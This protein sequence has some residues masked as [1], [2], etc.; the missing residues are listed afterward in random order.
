[1]N[2]TDRTVFELSLEHLDDITS[3]ACLRRTCKALKKVI[4]TKYVVYFNQT[5]PNRK[6]LVDTY[7]PDSFVSRIGPYLR[8]M[9]FFFSMKGTW[10]Y[11]RRIADYKVMGQLTIKH[12]KHIEWD[13]KAF[14]VDWEIYHNGT[15]ICIVSHNRP[16]YFRY[17]PYEKLMYEPKVYIP[18]RLIERLY[19]DESIYS[20]DVIPGPDD[21]KMIR[22]KKEDGS[23]ETSFKRCKRR[24][25]CDLLQFSWVRRGE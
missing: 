2:D 13:V 15:R 1:M 18:G 25:N 3:L 11:I 10:G 7:L 21:I 9:D 23:F 4:E 24:K 22:E 16:G 6:D 19:G 8:E 20:R 14:I 17:G 12:G 5:M